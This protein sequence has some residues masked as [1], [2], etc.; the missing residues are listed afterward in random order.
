VSTRRPIDGW[1]GSGGYDLSIPIDQE[2]LTAANLDQ[3]LHDHHQTLD[4]APD[5][6]LVVSR[7]KGLRETQTPLTPVL[8][9]ACDERR[10]H[11]FGEDL[12]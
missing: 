7:N 4:P 9:L 12:E 3:A 5:E 2:R 8:R 10:P 6:S 1:V 11:D